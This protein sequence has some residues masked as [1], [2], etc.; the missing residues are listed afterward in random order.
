M[1]I[2]I[3]GGVFGIM[4]YYKTDDKTITVDKIKFYVDSLR[5]EDLSNTLN[6]KSLKHLKH[7]KL[8]DK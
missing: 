1:I 8:N 7:N 3:I 5:Q 2:G 4:S 6:Q